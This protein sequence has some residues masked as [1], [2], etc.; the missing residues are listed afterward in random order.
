MTNTHDMVLRVG[1]SEALE[2][3]GAEAFWSRDAPLQLLRLTLRVRVPNNPILS[4]KP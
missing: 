3:L 4:P 2:A 1:V